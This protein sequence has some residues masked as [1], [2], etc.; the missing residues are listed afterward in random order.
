MTLR[1]CLLC[2]L[3]AV[4]AALAGDGISP[5]GS[6]TDYPAHVTAGKV[7]I[8]ASYVP[9]AQL[10]KLFGEDLDKR[11]YVV[12]EIGMF[13][14]D[15]TQTDVSADDFKLRQG[16][17]T[18]LTRAATPQM[19]ADDVR[20]QKATTP[21]LPENVHVYNTANIGYETGPYG[22]GGVY[23]GGG[24]GVAVGKDPN[25]PP[26]PAPRASGG[27]HDGLEQQL[28]QKALPEV[29]TTK[30]VAGYI[31]FPKP[32]A[33]KRADF[34]LLYFGQDGQVSLKLSP[35]AKP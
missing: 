26:P 9:P 25:A 16:K 20:P 32:S 24:T 34:E 31:F 14:V 17:D 30:A 10:K 29:K 3:L 8:G 18:S 33:D 19:I 6:A 2:L 15:S 4:A 13:P 22:R 21:K 5:L 35:T 23:A 11:G 28:E 7:A 1:L 12:F 27:D